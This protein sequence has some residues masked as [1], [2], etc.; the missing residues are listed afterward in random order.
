MKVRKDGENLIWVARALLH[1][2]DGE[3]KITVD[4]I[5]TLSEHHVSDNDNGYATLD[6][7]IFMDSLEPEISRLK[8][9]KSLTAM[10]PECRTT[11][12]TTTSLSME[13]RKSSCA[14]WIMTLQMA[15]LH[16]LLVEPQVS[17]MNGW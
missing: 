8:G 4:L 5:A 10:Q 6:Y 3:K 12:G 13:M 1:K 14:L 15:T 2:F 16:M 11:T 9:H 7:F 17:H